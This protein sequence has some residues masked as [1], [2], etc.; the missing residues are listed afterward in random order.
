[1]A[2]WKDLLG[3]FFRDET[4]EL[5][6]RVVLNISVFSWGL[7][8]VSWGRRKAALVTTGQGRCIITYITNCQQSVTSCAGLRSRSV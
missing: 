6:H 4:I 7:F 5:L 2:I 3:T 1:M 8:K